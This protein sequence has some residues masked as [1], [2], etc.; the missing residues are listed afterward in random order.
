[1]TAGQSFPGQASASDLGSDIANQQFLIRRMLG[2]MWTA[3]LV[4]V[5]GVETDTLTVDVQPLVAAVDSD[6]MVTPHGTIFGLPYFRLQGGSNAVIIDPV[7]G[8]IGVC[9]FASRDISSVKVAK[10]PSAPG[11]FRRFDPADGLYLGG[12]LNG[13]PTQLVSFG[14][15][16][17]AVTSPTAVVVTAPAV[18]VVSDNV[19]LG[20]T[21]GRPVA[22]VGDTVSGG[23]IT[24]GSEKV[25]A[26]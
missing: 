5:K 21:G 4:M 19:S 3:T 13:A 2:A 20:D 11:S 24:S 18:T 12:F 8:D 14:P 26:A 25:A 22:R 7:V 23:V 16:G 9:V 15:G 1:M 10:G 6:G 17:I